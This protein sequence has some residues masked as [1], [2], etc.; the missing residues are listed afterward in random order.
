VFNN[1]KTAG[2]TFPALGG[3]SAHTYNEED[4]IALMQEPQEDQMTSFLRHYF[5]MF[6]VVSFEIDI[7]PFFRV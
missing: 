1:E 6:F 3:S 2:D 7:A 4:L 5:S